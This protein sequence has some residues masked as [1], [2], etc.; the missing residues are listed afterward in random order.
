MLNG[1]EKETAELTQEEISLVP[2]MLLGFE[3]K[4]GKVN[5]VTNKEIIAGFKTNRNIVLSESRVRKLINYI[6]HHH[7]PNLVATNSGYY[8]TQDMQE[9]K[10]YYSSLEGR[11]NAIRAIKQ[12]LKQYM[13]QISRGN[14]TT[15]GLTK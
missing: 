1:F 6:R 11:E 14:Q 4:I 15:L 9:L 7:L 10:N 5:S 3:S 13:D 8:L 12:N 2:A